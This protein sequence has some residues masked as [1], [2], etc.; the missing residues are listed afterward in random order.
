MHLFG[1]AHI[2]RYSVSNSK[3]HFPACLQKKHSASAACKARKA[4]LFAQLQFSMYAKLKD[5]VTFKLAVPITCY[6]SKKSR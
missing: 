6:H 4:T 2:L 5:E 1:V 3:N